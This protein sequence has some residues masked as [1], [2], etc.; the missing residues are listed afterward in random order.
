MGKQ[1]PQAPAT[2]DYTGAAVAQGVANE[3]TAR[4]TA[5]LGNPNVY[6]PYGNQTVTFQGDTPTITQTLT[7]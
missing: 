5:K 4:L 7:P 3:A 6:S 2:P 1:T